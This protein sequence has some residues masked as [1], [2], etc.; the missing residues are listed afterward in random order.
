LQKHVARECGIVPA[1]KRFCD[2]FSWLAGLCPCLGRLDR[3][4]IHR[5][6]NGG[7][8]AMR[9]ILVLS[10]A[11]F[12]LASCGKSDQKTVV[13]NDKGDKVTISTSGQQFSMKSEDGKTSVTVNTGGV[14]AGDLKLP[15]FVALY[16]GAKVVSNVNGAGADNTGGMVSFETSAAPADVIAFYKQ[17]TAGAGL[18]E[19]MAMT[20]ADMSMFT[21]ASDDSKKTVAVTASP[22]DSGKG[23]RA[24]VTWSGG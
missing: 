4:S 21:A 2:A 3:A 12:A 14:A 20:Q 18:K 6:L 23:T 5:D 7:I 1:R 9:R 16:P 24:Q 11:A 13:V 22:G 19:K 8:I 10:L 15:A 17:N